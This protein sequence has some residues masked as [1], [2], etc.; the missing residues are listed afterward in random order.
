MIGAL[1]G[2]RRRCVYCNHEGNRCVATDTD[3]D[4]WCRGHQHLKPETP[5]AFTVD[6]GAPAMKLTATPDNAGRRQAFRHK[7]ELAWADF[8]SENGSAGGVPSF[9][10][11]TDDDDWRLEVSWYP[12]PGS[13]CGTHDFTFRP[14]S[15]A[16]WQDWLFAVQV[17][18]YFEETGTAGGSAWGQDCSCVIKKAMERLATDGE[19]EDGQ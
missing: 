4:G 10:C 7:V 5:Q 15:G 17:S 3:A 11:R 18:T 1:D 8:L 16:G 19:A 12:R 13:V 14:R 2:A 9:S 6:D